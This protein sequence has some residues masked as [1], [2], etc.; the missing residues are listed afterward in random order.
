ML[1]PDLFL[2]CF[3]PVNF[4]IAL[5]HLHHMCMDLT[6]IMDEEGRPC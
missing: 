1:G 3:G 6:V 5:F 4:D 2:L